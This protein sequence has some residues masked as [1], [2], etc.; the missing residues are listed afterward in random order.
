MLYSDLWLEA[1]RRLA[2]GIGMARATAIRPHKD[3]LAA[4]KKHTAAPATF[5]HVL[6]IYGLTT[7]QFTTLKKQVGEKKRIGASSH[8]FI[9]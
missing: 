6:K 7:K 1:D 9:N 5:G 2:N 8:A 4:A 3:R